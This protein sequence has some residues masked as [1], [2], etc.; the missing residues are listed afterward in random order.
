MTSFRGQTSR[1]KMMS[2]GGK[3]TALMCHP[4]TKVNI[5]E[6]LTCLSTNIVRMHK[7]FV[8]YNYF[9]DFFC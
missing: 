5:A 9:V 2:L 3:V 7:V 8:K 1:A 4:T 6:E